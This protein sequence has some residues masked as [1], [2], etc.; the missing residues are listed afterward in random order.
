MAHDRFSENRSALR[1]LAKEA[2]LEPGVY[3]WRDG[4]RRIIYVGKARLLRQRL[5]TYFN[6][7]DVKTATLIKYAASIETIIVSNEYEALLLEN[8]LIKQHSPKYNINLKDGKTYP[9]VRITAGSFP[10]VFRTRHIVEDGSLYFGPFPNVQA[11]DKTLDMIEKLF[12]LRKCRTLRKR[13]NPCM[14][15][16]IDRCL[17]PCCKE[18]PAYATQVERVRKLLAG[19]NTALVA[20]LTAK[21]REASHALRFEEAASLR[22]AIRAIENLA[23]NNSVEDMSM[24][25]RDYIA[26]AAQGIFT[27]FSVLSMRGGRMSGQELFSSRSAAG[28][29]ESLKTF[30]AAYYTP[31]RPPPPKVYLGIQTPAPH[32]SPHSPPHGSPHES[33]DPELLGRYFSGQFG[34]APELISPA[35]ISAGTPSGDGSGRRH[36]AALAMARQ[37]AQEELR[38]RLKERGAG[39]ALDELARA[40]G[41]KTRPERIEGFDV[42]QLDGR[43]PVAS[44]I[45]FKNGVPDRKQ[46]RYFKLRTVVGVV[47]DFA[48]IREAVYR[49]Y[50]RLV[51]EGRELP[52]L[53]LIDGGIGQVNAA[54]GVMDDLGIACDVAGLAKRDEEI[55]LP[56]SAKPV[57][58]S[59]RSEAL[60]VLQFV[61]DETH[62]FATGL[63]QKLRSADLYFP[64]LESVEGIGPKRAAAIMKAYGGLQA[65]AASEPQDIAEKCGITG[66]A[67]RAV[68]AAV[69]LALEDQR[70]KAGKMAAQGAGGPRRRGIRPGSAAAL[71][72]EA[73]AAE[74]PPEY[75]GD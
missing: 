41:L 40:L 57:L 39:P 2:P 48:A 59:K 24:E 32:D 15:Y 38:R 26:W 23:E 54:R 65:I 62:R 11:V 37:N 63:N 27:S 51:R 16:H 6:A 44:L 67:A 12:P 50:S 33:F 19:E 49:R 75:S 28:E 58:L 10:R 8:T 74:E 29:H 31:V 13:E 17:A 71:A 73:F 14:Y 60:K 7:K 56:H 34:F 36:I 9:V 47:D 35:A 5:A 53:V 64:V 52:D 43:H 25:D 20:E 46:Y 30:I 42:A 22:N 21:M 1:A 55:W 3:I 45:S 69:R 68:R 18:A 72:S 4:E 70:A 61:R 66:A